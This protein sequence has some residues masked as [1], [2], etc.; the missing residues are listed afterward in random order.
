MVISTE[1]VLV[2]LG[3]DPKE[4]ARFHRWLQEKKFDPI[5]A[6]ADFE[7]YVGAFHSKYAELLSEYKKSRG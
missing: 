5:I 6:V 4:L 7:G 1:V 2:K 3:T